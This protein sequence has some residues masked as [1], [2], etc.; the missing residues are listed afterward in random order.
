MD[1]NIYQIT[2]KS[3][4]IIEQFAQAGYQI[5]PAALSL[6]LDNEKH[7]NPFHINQIL[8]SLDDSILVVGPDHIYLQKKPDDTIKSPECLDIPPKDPDFE[9]EWIGELDVILDITDQSA[10]IGEYTDFLDYFKNRFYTLSNLLRNR[11]MSFRPIESLKKRKSGLVEEYDQISVI[12]MVSNLRTSKNGHRL[13]EIEDITGTFPVMVLKKERNLFDKAMKVMLDEVIGVTGTLSNDGNMLFVN[14]IMQP[15][16][17]LKTNNEL[18]QRN[19]KGKA[20]LISDMHVGSNTFLKN[21]WLNFI[22][23]IKKS[24]DINYLVIAGDIVDGIGIYPNQEK[25]L[26]INDIYEQYQA[27]AQYLNQIP[28]HIKIVLS[29]GNHDAVRQAEPQPAFPDRIKSFFN[30]DII[31][32][33]NPAVISIEGVRVLI[34]HGRS[35][36]DLIATIPGMKYKDPTRPMIEMLKC[37]HLSP[38]YGSRVSIAPEKQDHLVIETPPDILHCGH[39]HTVGCAK[40]R[41]VTIVNSGTWQSQTEFQRR[42]NLDPDPAKAVVV[43]LSNLNTT[44]ISFDQP[45]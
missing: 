7:Y 1:Q 24:N 21:E 38:I 4:V 40:Y 36:D 34:Y 43:D 3:S 8:S 13:I 9:D 44:I 14:N 39:V 17:P 35:I 12:G 5:D 42:M 25:E 26:Q 2:D 32:V 33:G 10:C 45:S 19:C 29:P 27:A 30:K 41:G 6:L 28:G 11:G 16:I 31:F 20:V 15:D 18:G 23:W 22:E 37:R